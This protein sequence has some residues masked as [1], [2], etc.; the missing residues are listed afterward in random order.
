MKLINAF[1]PELI[2][3]LSVLFV[4]YYIFVLAP[5]FWPA[6]RAF[7]RSQKLPRPWLFISVVAT[8]TYGVLLFICFAFSIPVSLYSIFIAPSI[9]NLGYPYGS[10]LVAMQGFISEWWIFLLPL[11]LAT[12]ACIITRRLSPR[13][14]AICTA[15]TA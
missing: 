10:W 7:R 5:V 2:T 9:R 3:W 8:Q 1:G 15:L 11:L 6:F 14:A 4:A 13:W 12:I